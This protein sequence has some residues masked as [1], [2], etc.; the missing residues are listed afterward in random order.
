[1][2]EVELT[3]DAAKGVKLAATLQGKITRKLVKQTVMTTVYG[4]VAFTSNHSLL[5]Q[6]LGV[7]FIGARD[8]IE[9]QLRNA[10]IVDA[11]VRFPAASYLAKLVGSLCALLSYPL[12]KLESGRPWN[13]SAISSLAPR[14]SKRG[15]TP[16]QS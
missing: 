10:D 9:R 1:M 4:M 5:T 8:Q 12:A 3:K 2:V 15:S 6:G 11:D 16:A 14:L 7:T 13:V